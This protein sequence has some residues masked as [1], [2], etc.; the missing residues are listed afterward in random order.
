MDFSTREK[1]VE[2]LKTIDDTNRWYEPLPNLEWIGESE[3]ARSHFFMFTGGKLFT[4][5]FG[6][7]NKRDNFAQLPKDYAHPT[8]TSYAKCVVDS[9]LKGIVLLSEYH[10]TK[11]AGKVWFGSFAFCKHEHPTQRNLGRCWNRYT[12]GD[13]GFSWEVD[14][15]G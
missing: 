9:H 12:C 5:A 10:H 7:P 6:G 14:S 15:S 4:R 2:F 1:I 13:C 11:D 8:W 3:F